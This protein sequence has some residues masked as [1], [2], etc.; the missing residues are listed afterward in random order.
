MMGKYYHKKTNRSKRKMHHFDNNAVT[1]SLADGKASFQMVLPMSEILFDVAGAIEQAAS[2]AGLRMMKALVDEEVEQLTGDRYRHQP[3]RQAIRWGKEDGHVIFAGRK[4]AM[5]RPRVRS[6]DSSEEVSLRRWDA[7]AHPRRMEQ[8][9]QNKILRR[10]SCRDYSGAIDDMCDGYGIDKSSVSRKWQAAS[11]KQ[12][13]Q[14]MERRLDDMDIC[15]IL[16]DGKEFGDTTII[17]ALGVDAAGTKH[18]LGLWPGATENSDV[19]GSLLDDMIERGLSVGM[20]YLFI[21][22]GS[23]AL[24]KAIKDRF[25]TVALIQRCR[26][27][28]ERNI[29]SYLPKKHHRLL[30]MKLKTAFGMTDYAE[31][32]RELTKVRDWLMSISDAAASSLEEGFEE[33]LT[34]NKLKLPALLKKLFGSTNMIESCYSV[35]GD[36]CRNVKRWRGANMAMRW[37]GAVLLETEKRFYRIRGHREMPM[38]AAILKR[39]VDTKEAVA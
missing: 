38:L 35:A 15:V 26:I 25:G 33:L 28:K 11:A 2:E 21:I 22:D 17:T 24:K 4:V 32:L 16:L 19:C 12:L 7:F 31:A 3:Q 39:N 13:A 6:K 36:L 30:A 37:A 5:E 8:A 18:I 1:V 34:V 14:L 10:V 23:K 20:Q 29:R 9:V 27:H